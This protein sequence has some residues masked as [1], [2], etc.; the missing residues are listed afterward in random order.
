[1]FDRRHEQLSQINI[2]LTINALANDCLKSSGSRAEAS[3]S[4]N[5][6]NIL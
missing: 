3:L 5:S 6:W 1:M 2:I 4:S